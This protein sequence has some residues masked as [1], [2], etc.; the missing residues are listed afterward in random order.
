MLQ[1]GNKSTGCSPSITALTLVPCLDCSPLWWAYSNISPL[2]ATVPS[3]HSHLH[4]FLC[5]VEICSTVLL[6]MSCI[7]IFCFTVLFH[8]LHNLCSDIWSASSPSFFSDLGV[9][10]IISN[11]SFVL[12]FFPSNSP[13]Q[14]FVLSQTCFPR[15]QHF[16]GAQQC[17]VVGPLELAVFGL[18]QPWPCIM[19]EPFSPLLLT[20][21]HLHVILRKLWKIG[22]FNLAYGAVSCRKMLAFFLQKTYVSLLFSSVM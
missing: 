5:S 15:C 14:Y 22:K 1:C 3:E 19:K 6:F 21:G 16:G 11:M 10:R 2:W 4:G 18:G 9:C 20:P 7:A 17:P 8:G 12:F 13:L